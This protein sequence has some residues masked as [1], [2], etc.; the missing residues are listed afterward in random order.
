[1]KKQRKE[2]ILALALMFLLSFIPGRPVKA[3]TYD[4]AAVARI[5]RNFYNADYY[6][7]DYTNKYNT[8]IRLM[9]S[10]A[11]Q[12]SIN[13]A[14]NDFAAA[15]AN[16]TWVTSQ[17]TNIMAKA[18]ASGNPVLYVSTLMPSD[19]A[20]MN[21]PTGWATYTDKSK[22]AAA[23]KNHTYSH[24]QLVNQAAYNGVIAQV[25]AYAQEQGDIAAWNE[26]WKGQPTP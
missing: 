25:G 17:M 16:K 22:Y 8:L 7:A 10:G 6:D 23:W 3:A 1:M 19:P 13:K 15:A 5:I 20:I 11:S 9:N 26:Y 24:S 4:E 14:M 12:K 18:K 2:M 21:E